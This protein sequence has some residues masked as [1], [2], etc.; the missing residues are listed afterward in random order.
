MGLK[1][2]LRNDKKHDKFYRRIVEGIELD[3]LARSTEGDDNIL[4]TISRAVRDGDAETDAGA[5]RFFTLLERN[6]NAIPVLRPDFAALDKQ[7]HEL[8]DGIPTFRRFHLRND[9]IG[10]NKVG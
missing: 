10:G 2:I 6:Q 1:L 3:S 5:H 9:L 8:D 7:I 4:Q